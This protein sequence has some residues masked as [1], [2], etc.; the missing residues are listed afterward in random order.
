METDEGFYPY[1]KAQPG[2][3]CT[4]A[5]KVSQNN[6]PGVFDPD[7]DPKDFEKQYSFGFRWDANGGS[8][9]TNHRA[10]ISPRDAETMCFTEQVHKEER[11]KMVVEHNLDPATDQFLDE[12]LSQMQSAVE[13]RWADR[14]DLGN[15]PAMKG[16]KRAERDSHYFVVL[17]DDT[18]YQLKIGDGCKKVKEDGH[19]N[20]QSLGITE[21]M[22]EYRNPPRS[23][24]AAQINDGDDVTSAT[25]GDGSSEAGDQSGY[26]A[27]ESGDEIWQDTEE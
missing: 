5:S 9:V 17:D 14:F 15:K 4:P 3:S 6:R 16:A 23:S 7:D 2:E 13:K 27:E 21:A 22:F 18:L 11:D 24:A 10:N 25:R 26:N 12:Q 1:G 20:L 19:W 8:V